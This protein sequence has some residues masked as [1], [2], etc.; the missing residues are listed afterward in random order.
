[1]MEVCCSLEAAGMKWARWGNE[2]SID[3]G[4]PKVGKEVTEEKKLNSEGN[5]ENMTRQIGRVL[6]VDW[7]GVYWIDGEQFEYE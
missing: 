7:L 3:A 4:T 2:R 6:L 1:M 5:M